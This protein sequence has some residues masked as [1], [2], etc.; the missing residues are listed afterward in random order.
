ML[1]I[2]GMDI[3]YIR[4]DDDGFSI[5]PT[6]EDG[7]EITG[8]TGVFSVKLWQDRPLLPAHTPKL[9]STPRAS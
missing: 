6:A 7:T 1:K 8:F 3:Y 4:G 2:R 5:Q 9:P